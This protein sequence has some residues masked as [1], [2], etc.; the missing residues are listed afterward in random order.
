MQDKAN[1]P[2]PATAELTSASG[3]KIQSN[4]VREISVSPRRNEFRG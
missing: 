3:L 1:A 4:R 2:M